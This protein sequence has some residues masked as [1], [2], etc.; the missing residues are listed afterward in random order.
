MIQDRLRYLGK[1]GEILFDGPEMNRV[2]T[3]SDE[4]GG[5]L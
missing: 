5:I 1:S 4:A 3:G 2:L